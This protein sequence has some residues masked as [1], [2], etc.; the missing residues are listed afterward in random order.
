MLALAALLAAGCGDDD[1]AG[2]TSTTSTS[3]TST[4]STSTTS[5]TSTSTT[6]TAS[7][8][9]VPVCDTD[10]VSGALDAALADA[11][12]APGGTWSSDVAASS[13]VDSTTTG[14]P[15]AEV[16]GLDCGAT[17]TQPDGPADRLALVSWTG[18]RMAFVIRALDGPSTPYVPLAP[19]S[20]GFDAPEGEYLRP[21]NSLWAGT[22][23]SGEALVVG[24]IDF[25]L[26]V[27]AKTW[28]ADAPPFGEEEPTLDAERAGIAAIEAAGGRNVGLAQPAEFGSEE[29]YV[30]FVSPTGQ[31]LVA[32]VAPVGWFDPMVPRYIPEGTTTI[33]TIDGVDVR[34]TEA[35]LTEFPPV[36]TEF[37]WTCGDF[38]WLMQP[39]GNGTGGETQ[40]FVADLVAAADC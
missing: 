6:S 27:A 20:I 7:T 33:E 34:M 37:G 40:A 22:L 12:L 11:R 8:L 9:P 17:V 35:E 30:M 2:S 19:V 14:E 18:P 15:W 36:P 28:S 10:E 3:T 21:D 38:V 32:D 16:L 1:G 29:G 26:G 5:T 25:N 13:F 31:I 4:T 23:E 24:H 39:A